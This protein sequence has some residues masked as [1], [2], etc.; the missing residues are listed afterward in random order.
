MRSEPVATALQDI[1]HHI[2]LAQQFEDVAAHFVWNTV[3]DALPPLRVVVGQELL[4][5]R[6]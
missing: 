1:L 2:D 4:R 6:G 5:H 3:H